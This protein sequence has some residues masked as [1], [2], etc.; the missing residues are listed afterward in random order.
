MSNTFGVPPGAFPQLLGMMDL[1]N[2]GDW[3][4]EA[5]VTALGVI[6]AVPA[7]NVTIPGILDTVTLGH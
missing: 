2:S 5:E 4:P 6:H 1:K 3:L 7:G